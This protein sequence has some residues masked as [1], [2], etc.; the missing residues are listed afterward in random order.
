MTNAPGKPQGFSS[1]KAQPPSASRLKIRCQYRLRDGLR[2]DELGAARQAPPASLRAFHLRK[3]CH[4]S[5]SRHRSLGS[6]VQPGP[7]AVLAPGLVDAHET[8]QA[9]VEAL[10]PG[11]R[12]QL[13]GH[14]P[15]QLLW[16]ASAGGGTI[17]AVWQAWG[18]DCVVLGACYLA[19]RHASSLFRTRSLDAV[20]QVDLPCRSAPGPAGRTRSAD[21]A[22]VVGRA[23]TVVHIRAGGIVPTSQG[24]LFSVPPS[25]L[26]WTAFIPS[27]DVSQAGPQGRSSPRA[28]VSAR[29]GA[30]HRPFSSLTRFLFS[31]HWCR[32]H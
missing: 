32:P 18:S 6:S 16:S 9:L 31:N 12:V 20:A 15:C 5:A 26:S 2:R 4:H 14:H 11:P 24:S 27:L 19:P 21:R 13:F 7:R 17:G 28:S 1:Q 29:S 10:R 3:G 30:L 8:R 23:R 25:D 22:V